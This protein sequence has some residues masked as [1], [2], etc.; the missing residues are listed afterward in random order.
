MLGATRAL[1]FNRLLIGNGRGPHPTADATSA[2]AKRF[3]MFVPHLKVPVGILR[4]AALLTP[5]VYVLHN[6]SHSVR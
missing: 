3:F 6:S 4:F 5:V 1:V 2:I